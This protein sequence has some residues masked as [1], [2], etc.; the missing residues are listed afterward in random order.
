MKVFICKFFSEDD[1]EKQISQLAEQK[2]PSNDANLKVF[3]MD[4]NIQRRLASVGVQSMIF[5]NASEYID[6]YDE[7]TWQETY[8]LSDELRSLAEDYDG[9]RFSGIN[10]L[11]LEYALPLYGNLVGFSRLCRQMLEQNCGVLLLVLTAPFAEWLPDISSP[12]IK[13]KRYGRT[14][15]TP[16]SVWL[17][18][19]G[20]RLARQ[21]LKGLLTS[22]KSY[23]RR[24]AKRNGSGQ[25]SGTKSAQD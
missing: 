3:C 22:A 14:F 11:T 19:H 18:Y 17:I 7:S 13:T 1:V 20:I 21:L 12:S 5:C 6:A 10:F 9:L 23:L 15:K 25:A 24:S 2:K 4:E 16:R 8:E